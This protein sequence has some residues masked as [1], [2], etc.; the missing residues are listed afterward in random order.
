M[1]TI[2]E[3]INEC[4]ASSADELFKYAAYMQ[5]KEDTAQKLIYLFLAADMI[6]EMRCY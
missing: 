6:Y 3:Y 4:L 1:M 2:Q 5:E